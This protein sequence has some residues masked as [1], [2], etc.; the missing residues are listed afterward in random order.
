LPF[1]IINALKLM[2]R[3]GDARHVT[4]M[5][6]LIKKKKKKKKKKK[7]IAQDRSKTITAMSHI[8]KEYFV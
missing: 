8:T 3:P 2:I 5:E 1:R 7:Y 4:K 6:S